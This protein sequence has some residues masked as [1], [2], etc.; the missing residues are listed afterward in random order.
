MG[1]MPD[2]P[3]DAKITSITLSR[4]VSGAPTC[5]ASICAHGDNSL[6]IWSSIDGAAYVQVADTDDWDITAEVELT[7]ITGPTKLRFQVDDNDHRGGLLATVRVQCDDGYDRTILTDDG[8]SNFDVVYSSSGNTV[9]S[10]F[11]RFGYTDSDN[12]D[13]KVNAEMVQCMDTNAYWMWNGVDRDN[14]NFELDL[15]PEEYF[16][17]AAAAPMVESHAFSKMSSPKVIE[18]KYEDA[19]RDIQPEPWTVTVTG[20]DLVILALIVINL[21]VC[22]ALCFAVKGAG[23]GKRGKYEAV[24]VISHS[25][26]EEI[27]V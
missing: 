3:D 22:T 13:S 25:E 18:R 14:V 10:V 2:I 24:G 20:K 23:N 21:C 8:N 17:A 5:S 6:E 15:F 4:T 16:G 1:L 7:D 9:M 12:W 19:V 27:A 11:H 26:M